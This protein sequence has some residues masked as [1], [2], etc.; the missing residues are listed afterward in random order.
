MKKGMRALVVGAGGIGCPAILSLAHGGVS[1]ICI[2]DDDY[3][4]ASNLPRQL[5]HWPEDLGRPKVDS[6]CEK[7]SKRFPGVSFEP[8]FLR[9]DGGNAAALFA[10]H[11]VVVDAT[12]ALE[13]KLLFSDIA[14]R[15]GRV[16]ISAGAAG[17]RGQVMRI[18]PG[19]SCLRCLFPEPV[20]EGVLPRQAG[21]LGP[22][23]GLLGFRAAAMVHKPLGLG[24]GTLHWIDALSWR[25]GVMHI[26][27]SPQCPC[28]G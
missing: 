25:T 24:R 7:L 19:G 9:V 4:E 15:G 10:E 21:I 22:L 12:D 1:K 28:H 23:A 18:E 8:L 3:V 14:A 11:P 2:A 17:W 16:L 13:S 27:K 6:A 26:E 20:Q 5:W